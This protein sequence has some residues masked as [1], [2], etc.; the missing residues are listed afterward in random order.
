MSHRQ[1]MKKQAQYYANR[2]E[3][4]ARRWMDGLDIGIYISFY[5]P[6]SLAPYMSFDPCSPACSASFSR[7]SSP[8]SMSTTKRTS[9]A[10]PPW[11][12]RYGRGARRAAQAAQ[13]L[14]GR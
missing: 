14:G 6:N 13:E 2:G 5:H 10:G 11:R 12:S 4:T 3:K 9:C 1:S 7:R 8:T